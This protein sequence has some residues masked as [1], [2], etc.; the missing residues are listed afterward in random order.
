[1]GSYLAVATRMAS[2]D[3]LLDRLLFNQVNWN[4]RPKGV[5]GDFQGER[6]VHLGNGRSLTSSRKSGFGNSGR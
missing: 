2:P 5:R 6:P 4:S 3:H 1:M